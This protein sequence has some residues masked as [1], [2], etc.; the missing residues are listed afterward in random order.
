LR[1]ASATTASASTAPTAAAATIAATVSTAVSA[2]IEIAASGALIRTVVEASRGIVLGWVV[3]WSKILRR[4][5]V[6]IGLALIIELFGM[7]CDARSSI[8]VCGVNFR[9]VRANF[10]I[11]RI[12]LAVFARRSGLPAILRAAERF[13]R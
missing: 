2:T 5:F 11:F 4:R 6:R 10:L 8:F 13:A 3:L 9:D 7:F 12:C 1:R